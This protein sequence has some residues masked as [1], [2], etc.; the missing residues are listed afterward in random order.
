MP[1]VAIRLELEIIILSEVSYTEKDVSF[2]CVTYKCNLKY[3]T[4]EPIYKH[5]YIHVYIYI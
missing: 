5:V 2:I 3:N 4:N 1:F